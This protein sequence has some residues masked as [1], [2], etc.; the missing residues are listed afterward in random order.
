[1]LVRFFF[2]HARKIF[3]QIFLS[4]DGMIAAMELPYLSTCGIHA[5]VCIATVACWKKNKKHVRMYY[6]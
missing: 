4:L 6:S 5:Y 2:S 3:D 1:M